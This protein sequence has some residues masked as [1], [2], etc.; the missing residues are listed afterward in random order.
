MSDHGVTESLLME[1]DGL[2][3][4][5]YE[6]GT[7]ARLR[8]YRSRPSPLEACFDPLE[9]EGLTRVR[10]KPLAVLAG[11]EQPMANGGLSA[12]VDE[13]ELLQNEFAMVGVRPVRSAESEG[14]L[15]QDMNG[16]QR[17]V[18][19]AGELGGLLLAKHMDFAPLIDTSDLDA[20]PEPE[21]D[22]L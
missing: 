8:C 2:R 15:I 11:L 10:H 3:V 20:L 22:E 12:E 17:V 6:T 9:L 16:G 5:R 1:L 19:S 14:L 18:L 4:S 21:I 7:G 13:L